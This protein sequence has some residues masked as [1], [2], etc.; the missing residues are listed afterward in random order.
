M[1]DVGTGGRS[2]TLGQE[3][4]HCGGGGGGGEGQLVLALDLC[5]LYSHQHQVLHL[6]CVCGY[7]WTNKRSLSA[8]YGQFVDT[9]AHHSCRCWD[10]AYSPNIHGMTTTA[11]FFVQTIILRQL[12]AL[13]G[14]DCGRL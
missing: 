13:H 1:R 14:R 3:V 6:Q 8:N 12:I 10:P 4:G 11:R 7:F 5:H 9:K 2:G